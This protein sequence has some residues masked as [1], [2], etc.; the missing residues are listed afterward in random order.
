MLLVALA[1]FIMWD[2][3]RMHSRP[4]EPIS[5]DKM[6]QGFLPSGPIQWQ[7]WLG[8]AG[9][10]LLLAYVEWLAPSKPPFTGHWGWL[11]DAAY[12]SLGASGT[13]YLYLALAC[14]IFANSFRLWSSEKSRNAKQ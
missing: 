14:L 7:I 6:S 12:Q 9:I 1:V 13:L 10:S 5:R 4:V 11:K 2:S 3:R 8:L